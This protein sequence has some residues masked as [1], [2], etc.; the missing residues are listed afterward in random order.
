MSGLSIEFN[1]LPPAS[2]SYLD[3]ANTISEDQAVFVEAE[4]AKLL[5]KGV[6][7]TTNFEE[8][9]FVSPIF[10]TPKSDGS[11]RLIL[12]LKK[13]NEN[14]PQIH[15]KMDTLNTVFSLITPNCFMAKIDFQDAYY[16]VPIN[17][18]HQKFLKFCFKGV[19]YKFTCLPNGLSP[20][21]R[22]FTK[23]LK[24]PL[25]KLRESYTTTSAYIDD[26]ITLA[27]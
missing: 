23:L 24:P 13:L 25:A 3:S 2:H 12:N 15:F 9:D 6:L 22:R 27:S 26:I 5:K 4:I 21:P 20:G 18:N 14:T 7:K 10:L 19:F 8:G 1:D 16:S 11:F 17:E